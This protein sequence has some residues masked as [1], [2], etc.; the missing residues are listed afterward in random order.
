MANKKASYV[1]TRNI[2]KAQSLMQYGATTSQISRI[3]KIAPGQAMYLRTLV[4]N[5]TKVSELKNLNTKTKVE[6]KNPI[7][8]KKP[9]VSNALVVSKENVN[10]I[11][12]GN[13]ITVT[14]NLA[15]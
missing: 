11:R 14:I 8:N 6:T 7:V 2:N 1:T 15:I 4:N 10:V 13:N 5:R 3:M 12:T 9:R